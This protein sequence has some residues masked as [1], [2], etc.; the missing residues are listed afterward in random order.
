MVAI[1]VDKSNDPFFFSFSFFM[2][3]Q[4]IWYSKLEE[5]EREREREREDHGP[6]NSSSYY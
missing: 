2:A 5:R 3:K 1:K 4:T 6:S